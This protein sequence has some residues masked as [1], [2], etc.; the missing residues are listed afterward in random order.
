MTSIKLPQIAANEA[1]SEFCGGIGIDGRMGH[2][3]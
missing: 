2:T 3:T 1:M